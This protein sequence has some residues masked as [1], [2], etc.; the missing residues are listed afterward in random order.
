VVTYGEAFT[1]QPFSN[2]MQTITL[3]GA[4]LKNVLEEQWTAA[5]TRILQISSTLHYRYSAAAPI[6][7]KVSD[8]TV[9]G[10]PLDPAAAYRVS[11]NNFLAAGGDGFTEFTR[12]TD[13]TGGPV[14]L[15]AFTAYLGAHSPL[16]P[17]PADRITI[18][19]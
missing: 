18:L 1:V 6:G 3:T 14:D 11:V 9:D 12:G 10:S 7:S 19:P 13:L 4:S 2:I 16:S 8:I 15:D 5:T 17:P